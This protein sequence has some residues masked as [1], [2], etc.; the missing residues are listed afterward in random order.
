MRIPFIL[1]AVLISTVAW[2]RGSQPGL[3]PRP[4]PPLPEPEVEE[5]TDWEWLA[6]DEVA[7]G[8][9][10]THPPMDFALDVLG[11]EALQ[12]CASAIERGH[13]ACAVQLAPCQRLVLPRDGELR[14]EMDP[15]CV[16]RQAPG[17]RMRILDRDSST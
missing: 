16:A 11:V 2:A 7:P 8:V 5:K 10:V 15:V 6:G 3:A 17:S 4:L 13:E 1:A 14:L 12:R 9:W